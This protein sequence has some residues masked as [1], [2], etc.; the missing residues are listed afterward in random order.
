MLVTQEYLSLRQGVKVFYPDNYKDKSA[1]I[2]LSKGTTQEEVKNNLKYRQGA[3]V[4]KEPWREIN[5]N[6]QSLI[7][8]GEPNCHLNEWNVGS[9]LGV[10]RVPDYIIE[11]LAPF[12][13]SSI[14]NCEEYQSIAALPEGIKAIEEVMQR[15]SPYVLSA[16]GLEPLG[17][18]VTKPN[19]KTVTVNYYD[20]LNEKLHVGMHLDSWDKSPLR[21]RHLS[22]N[23][24]CIN[25]GREDRFFLFIN[26]TLMEMFY[27]LGLSEP[28]DIY[29]HYRGTNLGYEF[30]LRYPDYPVVKIK[31]SPQEAYIA[32]T[33]N[34]IHD[35]STIGKNYPDITLT[36][37]GYFGLGTE[38]FAG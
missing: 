13:L 22:R 2:W 12:N 8:S 4:P 24:L 5:T 7:Y 17:I 34:L 14:D 28:Q 30:M 6:E 27:A 16:K 18:Q 10:F 35:A 21:R 23:R 31:V 25:L 36:Y 15:L 38:N 29:K 33:D 20:N 32:P 37:I 3:F 11:P 1:R 19:L 9:H 26:L